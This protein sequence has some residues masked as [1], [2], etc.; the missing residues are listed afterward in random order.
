MHQA[1][2]GIVNERREI[3]SVI[4]SAECNEQLGFL[5]GLPWVREETGGNGV[6]SGYANHRSRE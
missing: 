2:E 6:V 1:T 4:F 3:V 5:H